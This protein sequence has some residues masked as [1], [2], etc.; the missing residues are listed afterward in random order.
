M[1][2]LF[3]QNRLFV[4]EN[5][6]RL[7]RELQLYTYQRNK[8]DAQKILEEPEKKFD[9]QIDNLRYILSE[10]PDYQGLAR[11]IDYVGNV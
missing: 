6:V 1:N 2:Q 10:K 11:V 8:R 7:H 5:C 3:K 4:F 9:D